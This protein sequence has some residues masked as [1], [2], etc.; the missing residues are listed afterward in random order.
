MTSS[1][2]KI[3]LSR[4]FRKLPGKTKKIKNK[5]EEEKCTSTYLH[6]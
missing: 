3:I 2:L 1:K 4:A 5:S 6:G